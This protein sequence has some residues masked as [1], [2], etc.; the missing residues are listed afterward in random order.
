MRYAA[1]TNTGL[2]VESVLSASRCGVTPLLKS[3]EQTSAEKT[4]LA[5]GSSYFSAGEDKAFDRAV[6]EAVT[7]TLGL[8]TVTQNTNAVRWVSRF[9]RDPA[10]ANLVWDLSTRARTREK[11][12]CHSPCETGFTW[13]CSRSSQR[14]LARFGRRES[15]QQAWIAARCPRV[16]ML[17]SECF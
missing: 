8:E 17:T 16:V 10:P 15:S 7:D 6:T 13:E 3:S 11:N 4:A 12:S 5:E 2:P 1:E 9:T 14:A